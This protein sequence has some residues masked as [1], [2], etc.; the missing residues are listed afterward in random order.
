MDW[1][2]IK[3]SHIDHEEWSRMFNPYRIGDCEYGHVNKRNSV[4][5]FSSRIEKV[6]T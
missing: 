2:D 6:M 4:I 3:G 1:Y 5:S